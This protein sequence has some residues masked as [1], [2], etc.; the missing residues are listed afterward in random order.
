MTSAL[1]CGALIGA[2]ALCATSAFALDYPAAPKKPVV[3]T[4]HGVQVTDDYQWLEK[5]DDAAVK[6]WVAAEN[7]LTRQVL[8][9]VPGR[10]ALRERIA[11]LMTSTSKSYFG[12]VERGGTIFAMK[13]QPPKQQP[14]LVTLKTVDSTDGEQV[15]LDPNALSDKG[16]ITIDFFVPSNDGRKVA[17]SLSANGSEDGTVHVYDVRSGKEL[18]D[19][20]PRAQYPTGGGSLAWNH[21]GSGFYVTR[22][23]APGERPEADVHFFQ[24]VWFHKLGTPATEDRYEIGQAFPRIAEIA[25]SSSRD[26]RSTLALV[27]N[28][29]GGEH[30]LYLRTDGHGW[31]QVAAYADEVKAAQFG[32]DGYVYLLSRQDAPMG[33]VL[34]VPLARAAI[35]KAQLVLPPSDG[36]IQQF[37]VADGQLMVGEL[38]GGPS[39]LRALDLKTRK[40]QEIALPP[41]SSVG[42]IAR[43]GRGQMVARVASYVLPPAWFHVAAGQEPRKS[44]LAVTSAADYADCEVLREFATSKDGTKVPLTI[45]QRKGTP[46]DGNNPTILYGYGGYGVSMTPYFSASRR[47]WLD[48]GGVL[49]VANLRGGGEYGEAWHLAGNLTKKQTVFDDFIASA[50]YLI[51]QKITSPKRLAA[52]GGSNGGL[53]MGAALTQRPELFRAVHSAVGIYDMLRVELDP[54]GAFN[55]TEFGSVKDKAQFEALYGYSPLHR[56]KDGTDY[57]AVLMT[58]G[59]NDGRVNPAHSRK[60]IARLQAADPSGQ[61]ILLRTNSASGHGIG[62]ALSEAIE[63]TTDAYTFLFHELGVPLTH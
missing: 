2:L 22:Y 58:T 57:P 47:A 38:L 24:Q 42:D 34:R 44:A 53:L 4:Y 13:F 36:T 43:V 12:L 61:P 32:E 26:G 63:E 16:A 3:D 52:Q 25:L 51:A 1:R 46:R 19:Q 18:G 59:D 28:G 8:D 62:T 29:D 23:P 39:R 49:V 33:K 11:Q 56:V 60:M 9:E 54:N 35:D 17:V 10:A 7:K 37:E 5:G 21:D 14:M 50:Q 55:V 40:L 48:H 30:A 45:V 31:R 20:V 6:A 41:V 15:V 27:S